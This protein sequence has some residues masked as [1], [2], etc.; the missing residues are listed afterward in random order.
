MKS[1]KGEEGV[2]VEVE[3]EGGGE[4]ALEHRGM[5]AGL[6]GRSRRVFCWRGGNESGKTGLEV[7]VDG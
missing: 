4:R 7:G 1:R 6:K 2:E 3:E 5:R